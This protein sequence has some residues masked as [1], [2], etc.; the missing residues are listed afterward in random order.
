MFMLIID[1]LLR[2]LRYIVNIFAIII[3]YIFYPS[4][5]GFLPPIKNDLL[6]QPAIKLA[7]KIKSGQLK[8]EDLVQAYI[9]RCKK[10]NGDLN[11]IV[12]DNFTDALQE[13]RNVDERVQRELRG[14]K[15]PDESS[16][17]DYPFL[18]IPYTAKNSISVKGF[19][20]TCGTYNRKGIVA[21]KDCTTIINMRKS[22]A[23]FLALTNVPDTTLF[24]DSFN[25]LDGQTNNPYDKSRVP[26]GSSGGEAALI[27][28]AGSV[29]GIGSDIGGSLRIPA[30]FCGIFSHCTTAGNIVIDEIFPPQK[31]I[32]PDVLTI[33]PMCRYACDLR[34]M[35]KVMTGDKLDLTEKPFNYSDL[36][37][38]YIRDL[39]DPLALPVDVEILKGLDKMVRHFIENGTRTMELNMAKG[40]PDSFYDFRLAT[41]FWL[42]ALHDPQMPS[43]H[44]LISYGVKMNPYYELIKCF[45]GTQSRYAA[46]PLVI[47][48][49]QKVGDKFLTKDFFDKWRK[50]QSNLHKLLENDGVI[51]CP[52]SPEIAPKHNQSLLKAFDCVYTM[53]WNSM[54]VAITTIPMGIDRHG[55]PFAIQVIAAPNNDKLSLSIV[56]ELSKHFGGW[57]PPCPV[58]VLSSSSSSS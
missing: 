15:L 45:I 30:H 17:H 58:D 34:P 37:V 55:M 13:A 29:L 26:G 48:I 4:Q 44:E 33:G 38:Y 23:I 27:A 35:L 40:D 28:S 12:H 19:T 11:T 21:D 54:N 50:T 49:T 39:G 8:S 25:Y 41:L 56:E 51:L 53:L 3:G 7:Q 24:S 52:I 2:Q 47:G 57:I 5:Q 18:G 36:N 14:E 46:G 16:I 43:Y 10:V 31:D 20:F 22:G 1:L 6:L 42:A 9:D 32:H